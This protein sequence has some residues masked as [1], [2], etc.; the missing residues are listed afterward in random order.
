MYKIVIIRV[1]IKLMARLT[2]K[3]IINRGYITSVEL[4][5]GLMDGTYTLEDDIIKEGLTQVG[6]YDEVYSPE[7]EVVEEVVEETVTEEVTEEPVKET[8]TE[9]E[10]EVTEETEETVTEEV[11][12]EPVKE[13]VTEPELEVTE[14]PVK[15]T[16]TEEVTEEPVKETVT[17]PELEV[18]EEPVKETVTEEVTEEP[19]KETVTEPELEVTEETEE[20]VTEPELEVTE[21]T[22]E[23]VTE[24]VK[25]INK[26]SEILDKAVE[27]D[28]VHKSGS[29][30]SYN[31][32]KLG[33][34]K[35]V[36]INTLSGNPELLGEIEAKVIGQTNNDIYESK[37]TLN[38]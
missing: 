22:E 4:A 5:V 10:L 9:P 14:E 26:C 12:E 25:D 24:S 29:W 16:V 19:V 33:Q 36:V 8:V 3:E 17:E 30:Y 23:T 6:V 34:G 7:P 38:E 37:G 11:T 15:E 21:E 18:T 35:T 2:I 20:T 31:G 1:I 13:T 32:A 27:L 28:I